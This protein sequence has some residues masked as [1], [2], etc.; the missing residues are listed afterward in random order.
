[1]RNQK[2]L[3]LL[4]KRRTTIPDCCTRTLLAKNVITRFESGYA[5]S[6]HPYPPVVDVLMIHQ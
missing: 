6:V 3:E 2:F 4:D 5:L 1:L